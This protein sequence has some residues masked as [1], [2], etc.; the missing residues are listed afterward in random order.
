M[1]PTLSVLIPAYNEELTI[2]QTIVN[3]SKVDSNIYI[4]IIDNNS[5]DSTQQIARQTLEEIEND[6]IVIFEPRQGKGWAVRAGFHHVFTDFVVMVDADNTYSATDL[7]HLLKTAI[8]NNVDMLLGSRLINNQYQLINKRKF[9]SLG[10]TLVVN[11]VNYF[12]K[13]ALTDVM[14]GYR[15][16]SKKFVKNYPVLSTGFEIETEMTVHGLDKKYRIME[17][18][19]SYQNRPAGS[20]SKLSTFKDGYRVIKT[21]LLI[22]KDYRPLFFFSILGLLYTILGL[23]AGA[24]V[25]IEFLKTQYVSHV[26]LAIL[27]TGLMILSLLFY[28]IGIILDTVVKQ[29]RFNYELNLLK[30]DE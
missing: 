26:P 2:A 3:F 9:H 21:L 15:V 16:F 23:L 5:S 22:L 25:L 12:F 10:N 8:S 30:K 13:S 19:I 17:A 11:L 18:P 7:T 20:Y 1:K 6:G 28:S 14:T 24:P 4:I 29:H 27:A